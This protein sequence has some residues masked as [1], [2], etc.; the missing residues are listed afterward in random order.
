M[1]AKPKFISIYDYAISIE[2]ISGITMD[3]YWIDEEGNQCT[4]L[5]IHSSYH[6][7]QHLKDITLEIYSKD[8][9]SEITSVLLKYI[10][11]EA[12][13]EILNKDE[14]PKATTY[15]DSPEYSANKDQ[16]EVPFP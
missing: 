13:D 5:K 11:V 4:L 1:K 14:K 10:D 15:K 12:L 8:V 2:S 6:T 9:L 7:S 16:D 3:H